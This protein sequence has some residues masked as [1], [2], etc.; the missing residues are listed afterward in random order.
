MLF[1][2]QISAQK[3]VENIRGR[4][5]MD[6]IPLAGVHVYNLHNENYTVTDEHGY[7]TIRAVIGNTLQLTH[8]GL[9]TVFRTIVKEDVEFAGVEIQMKE[10][11]TELEGVEV[12]KYQKITAQDLGILQHKPLERT[13]AEKRLYSSGVF[14]GGF[15]ILGVV[16][17]ITGRRKMLKKVVMNERNTAIA[18]YIQEN[19]GDFLKKELKITDEEVQFLSYYVMENPEIHQLVKSKDEKTL[20]FMLIDAWRESQQ[21]LENDE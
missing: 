5:L 13:F 17:I 11:V 16:D 21:K 8:V 7:F 10:Q 9:Q 3:I 2:Q 1:F 12:S 6:S 15:N 4:I 19:M 20:Q 14:S 18:I